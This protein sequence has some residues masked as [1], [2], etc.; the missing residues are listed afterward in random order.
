MIKVHGVLWD[1]D[2]VLVDAGEYHFQAWPRE[3]SQKASSYLTQ[4]SHLHLA[5]TTKKL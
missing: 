2:G 5:K 4:I 3:M 1:M